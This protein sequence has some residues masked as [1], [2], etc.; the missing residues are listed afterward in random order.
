MPTYSRPALIIS[1]AVGN[2]NADGVVFDYRKYGDADWIVA[3]IEAPDTVRKVITDVLPN[4][5]YEVGIR[6]KVRGIIG[7][8]LELGPVTTGADSSADAIDDVTDPD[9]LTPASIVQTLLPRVQAQDALWQALL[10]AFTTLDPQPEPGSPLDLALG[11]VVTARV[12]AALITGPIFDDPDTWATVDMDDLN[13]RLEA[14]DQALAELDRLIKVGAPSGTTVAGVPAEDVI[15]AQ[16]AQAALNAALEADRVAYDAAQKVD[17]IDVMMSDGEVTYREQQRI[18]WLFSEWQIRVAALIEKGVRYGRPV[19]DLQAAVDAA[20]AFLLAIP[21]FNQGGNGTQPVDY[22]DWLILSAELKAEET[23]LT[24]A[25]EA[26]PDATNGSNTVN[27]NLYAPTATEIP[28]PATFPAGRTLRMGNGTIVWLDGFGDLTDTVTADSPYVFVR[29]HRRR[30]AATG[31]GG[32]AF[33]WQDANGD[34][35]GAPSLLDFFAAGS[36]DEGDIDAIFARPDGA[37][38]IKR[39]MVTTLTA[40][41][42]DV[43]RP[44]AENRA[45]AAIDNAEVIQEIA[46]ATPVIVNLFSNGELAL[47]NAD[48]TAPAGI[49]S[50]VTATLA[51]TT[52]VA[53]N[54]G[55][56]FKA[57]KRG[58]RATWSESPD[59]TNDTLHVL[60]PAM[61]IVRGDRITLSIDGAFETFEDSPVY[62]LRFY[63]HEFDGDLPAG[64]SHLAPTAIDTQ[65]IASTRRVSIDDLAVGAPLTLSFIPQG[66]AALRW[67]AIEVVLWGVTELTADA[68]RVTKNNVSAGTGLIDLTLLTTELAPSAYLTPDYLGG[69]GIYQERKDAAAI[70]L[71][72]IDGLYLVSTFA[73]VETIGGVDKTYIRQTS[74]T[75]QTNYTRVGDVLSDVW[76]AWQPYFGRGYPP[77][78]TDLTTE[79]GLPLNDAAVVTGDTI[80]AT[81]AQRFPNWSFDVA[82]SE[83]RPAGIR[84]VE[85]V[86]TGGEVSLIRVLG[87]VPGTM[88]LKGKYPDNSNAFYGAGFPAVEIDDKRIYTITLRHYASASSASGLTLRIDER[89][90]PLRVG[91]THIGA[92]AGRAWRD[93]RTSVV[94]LLADGPMPGTSAA[95]V[96]YEYTPTLGTRFGTFAMYNAGTGKDYR[97]E[98]VQTSSRLNPARVDATLLNNGPREGNADVTS[99]S[100]PFMPPVPVEPAPTTPLVNHSNTAFPG[101]ASLL[102]TDTPL[103][104]FPRRLHGDVDV[105]MLSAWTAAVSSGLAGS[106]DNSSGSPS[107]GRVL[108]DTLNAALGIIVVEATYDGATTRQ[109]LRV[110]KVFA[111]AYV[112]SFPYSE[113]VTSFFSPGRSTSYVP[114]TP[115][116]RFQNSGG[117]ATEMVYLQYD[118]SIPAVGPAA[119]N[120]AV[121][122]LVKLQVAP[123]FTSTSWADVGALT[124]TSGSAKDYRSGADR[125]IDTANFTGELAIDTASLV[126]AYSFQIVAATP[127]NATALDIP[128]GFAALHF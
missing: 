31:T 72:G 69:D 61:P 6:Y 11:A 62:P 127:T 111:A 100:V 26:S 58:L 8:R 35:V 9:V 99:T 79:G 12:A 116:F 41:T 50:Y 1:G 4:T 15:A 112:G 118:L 103:L 45:Y 65:T 77:R 121:T 10:T 19:D 88:E 108:I 128:V 82:N 16:V 109:V 60:L 107:R 126:A 64:K 20:Y 95:E 110:P 84:D 74:G 51:S 37:V 96:T 101:G 2:T 59:G 33:Q 70:G 56:A 120:N 40:G 106:I 83:N 71:P 44:F 3:A 13:A 27:D 105:T 104:I 67:A 119:A 39:F 32:L 63:L 98:F 81:S 66:G 21:N 93:V 114:I 23:K 92:D 22:A 24:L 125:I 73:F 17:D 94:E 29:V 80:S 53:S 5:Q 97:V 7:D 25:T 115:R 122:P 102:S 87:D 78:T 47:P 76:D 36:P 49:K 46:D 123:S 124:M 55:L 18:G 91:A 85:N 42:V 48:K 14:V 54:V 113:V 34:A 38:K 117:L 90:A 75:A 68:I 52:P 28:T 30:N 43:S 86:I 57:A 89:D